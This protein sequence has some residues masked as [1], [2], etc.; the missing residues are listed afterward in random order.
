MEF[1]DIVQQRRSIRNF[2]PD[3]VAQETLDALL[4][5]ALESPSSSN[6]Q[7]FKVAIAQGEI[8]KQIGAEL[9]DKYWRSTEI[10]RKPLIQKLIGFLTS[11]SMPDSD[12]KP[13][14]GKYPGI[15]QKRR[16]ATGMGLYEV[17]GIDRKDTKAR[18]EHMAKNF[19]FFDAPVALFFFVDPR[20][21]HT[22]LVDLGIFMQSLMLGATNEGLGTC[23]MGALGIWRKPL[24]KHFNIPTEYK[25]VCGMALGYP[26]DAK[27][28][29]Y[30]PEKISLQELI[31]PEA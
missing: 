15:F 18:D 2:K 3:P 31:I 21:T 7:P 30:R 22:A 4:S 16:V 26:T 29:Q 20:M 1:N 14:L 27:V 28:N 24:D 25:L 17:L 9:T 11:D 23:A 5:Q 13:I 19:H 12:F 8:A 6:S 10:Q